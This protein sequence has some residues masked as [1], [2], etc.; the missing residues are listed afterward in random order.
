MSINIS[1]NSHQF[2]LIPGANKDL[3][4]KEA[5]EEV[6]GLGEAYA[7]ASERLNQPSF[8][9]RFKQGAS[10]F[11]SKFGRNEAEKVLDPD[12][13]MKEINVGTSLKMRASEALDKTSKYLSNLDKKHLFLRVLT[14]TSSVAFSTLGALAIAGVLSTPIGWAVAGGVLFVALVASITYTLHKYSPEQRTKAILTDL[15]FAGAGLLIGTGAVT[16]VA[17]AA[18]ASGV[19]AI[20]VT[21]GK[22]AASA[23]TAAYGI[24]KAAVVAA[25]GVGQAIAG[26][27]TAEPIGTAAFGLALVSV[28]G[29]IALIYDKFK[30]AMMEKEAAK[31]AEE[32]PQAPTLEIP[33]APTLS[34]AEKESYNVSKQRERQGEESKKIERKRFEI[35]PEALKTPLPPSP[36]VTP[37]R[38]PQFST[39]AATDDEIESLNLPPPHPPV[40]LSKKTTHEE[41]N[42]PEYIS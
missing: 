30:K 31:K 22:G 24:G 2:H 27:V 28:G 33:Q 37:T 7:K 14:F 16:A 9:T 34:D 38:P 36:P 5:E 21:V 42:M 40:S 1:S 11:L 8:G 17:P 29:V 13:T 26:A 20:A 4:G 18:F 39:E 15:A 32:I 3:T 25:P 6:V 10:D 19:A 12:S 41:D 23:G 35:D